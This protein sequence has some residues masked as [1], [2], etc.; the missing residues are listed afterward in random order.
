MVIKYARKVFSEVKPKS[1]K[2]LRV[3]SQTTL[4]RGL[5]PNLQIKKRGLIMY[6][7]VEDRGEFIKVSGRSF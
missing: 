5:L 3:K 1:L 6:A 7:I 2:V 4:K